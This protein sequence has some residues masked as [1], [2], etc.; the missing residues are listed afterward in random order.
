MIRNWPWAKTL[1]HAN[2]AFTIAFVIAIARTIAVTNG[3]N[4]A[5]TDA[6]ADRVKR[7][8]EKCNNLSQPT[9]RSADEP[10]SIFK[11]F[12]EAIASIEHEIHGN[13]PTRYIFPGTRVF[14]HG[15]MTLAG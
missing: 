9:A 5:V 15:K 11:R 4:R 14:C 3:G 2:R 8:F 13:R 7:E 12:L 6:A 10:P 1:P